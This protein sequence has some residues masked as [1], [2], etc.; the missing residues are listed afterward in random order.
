MDIQNYTKR[1]YKSVKPTET[2]NK[3]RNIFSKFDYFV[4]EELWLNVNDEI[5]SAR[6]TSDFKDGYFGTNGKGRTR[7]FTLASA[8]AEHI[9]RLQNQLLSGTLSFNRILLN[10]IKEESGFFYFP[11]ETFIKKEEFYNLPDA[12]FQDLHGSSE[13]NKDFIESYYDRIN[14]NSYEG[15]LGVPFYDVRNDKTINFPFNFLQMLC[16]SNGMAA[17][18]TP[19]EAIFQAI[20]ELI[21]RYC[22]AQVFFKR[23]TPPT[24]PDSFLMK[25]TAEF[26]LLNKIREETGYQIIVKDFSANT[27][28]PAV[29]LIIIDSKN[30][31][32]RLNIG[33][34]TC[35]PVALSRC[36]TEI[37]QGFTNNTI[38]DKMIPIPEK[39]YEHFTKDNKQAKILRTNS[40]MHHCQNATGLFS[41]KLFDATPSYEFDEEVFISSSRNYKEELNLLKDKILKYGNDIYIRDNSFLGFPTYHVYIPSFSPLGQESAITFLN[42]EILIRDKYEDI[43]FPFDELNSEKMESVYSSI[44]SFKSSSDLLTVKSTVSYLKSMLK[45][46]FKNNYYWNSLPVSFLLLLTYIKEQNFKKAAKIIDVFIKENNCQ[47]NKYY[48]GAKLYL[49]MKTKKYDDSKIISELQKKGFDETMISEILSDL[50]EN[51]VMKGIDLP[52]CPDCNS[53]TIS[54]NCLTGSKFRKT[55]AINKEMVNCEINQNKVSEAFEISQN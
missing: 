28:L 21:E 16:G 4:F 26:S 47:D 31:K 29:G 24:I 11:D 37:Y 35:F 22:A 18:N 38:Q 36:I 10:K 3:I 51:N 34:E 7:E 39:E 32:Y 46:E 41:I 2:V 55:I 15:V 54:E 20:C 42:N 43:M 50:N 25:Y 9:E 13:F 5:Y 1:K 8:Y 44:E 17:G 40:F 27:K 30:G 12:F 48:Q 52:S 19:E 45:L 33:A 6:V 49:K 14:Q 53:C 23:L